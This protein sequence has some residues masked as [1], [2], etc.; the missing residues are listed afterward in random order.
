MTSTFD[1]RPAFQFL[2]ELRQNNQRPWFAQ[3]RAAYD[4]ALG[5]FEDF[6]NAMIYELR[7]YDDLRDLTA[8]Q[9]IYRIYR[10]VRFS[11]DKV[12]YKTNLSAMIAPGGRKS[13]RMGYYISIEPGN[14]TMMAGG[15][16]SPTPDQLR[17]F[18]QTVAQDAT[19]LR[20]ITQ[21]K[22]FQDTFGAIHGE[23]LKTAPQGYDRHHPEIDLLCL[24]QVTAWRS[25]TDGQ[26]FADDFLEQTLVTCQAMRPFLGYLSTLGNM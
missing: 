7:G 15:L 11:K 26:V 20:E 5:T 2:E 9:C 14:H 17:G 23:R 25:F 22:A 3:N 12:P 1:F 24:K 16:Y 10:D 8:K 4:T 21:A 18:R 19:E 13:T 6:I